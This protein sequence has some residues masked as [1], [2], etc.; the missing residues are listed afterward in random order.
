MKNDRNKN[1]KDIKLNQR[2]DG[3]LSIKK[4]TGPKNQKRIIDLSNLFW[5]FKNSKAFEFE[6]LKLFDLIKNIIV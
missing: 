1:N 3:L 5:F 2:S 6:K 4:N